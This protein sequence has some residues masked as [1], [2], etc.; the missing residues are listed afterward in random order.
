MPQ[1]AD[2]DKNGSTSLTKISTSKSLSSN[3]KAGGNKTSGS[4]KDA[5]KASDEIERYHVI[6][7]QMEDINNEL[8]K[9]SKA[10]DRAFGGDKLKL[11]DDEIAKTEALVEA[12]K[13]YL[14]QIESYY[15]ADRAAIAAYGAQFDENGVIT[16]Y[17]A[18]ISAQIAK[19]NAARTDAAEEEFEK[20]KDVLEQYEE[21]SDLVAEERQKLIDQENE[22]ADLLLEKLQ[23]EIELKIEIEDDDL[24]YLDFLLKQVN[25]SAYEAADAIA[26]LGQKTQ[27]TFNKIDAYTEGINKLFQNHGFVGDITELLGDN[28]TDL[29]RSE[30]VV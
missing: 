10:K 11:M 20:F 16:N 26:L 25:D 17:D 9:I 21:T 22:L 1:I 27:S 19:F 4:Q 29:L 13:E 5:K 18:L 3:I 30:S 24:K 8:D 2:A 14:R 28:S 7:E 15:G 23:Y 6:K 12:Q